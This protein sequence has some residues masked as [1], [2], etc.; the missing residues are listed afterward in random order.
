M[1]RGILEQSEG[2]S[3]G[4][5]EGVAQWWCTVTSLYKNMD[6]IPHSKYMGVRAQIFNLAGVFPLAS[7]GCCCVWCAFRSG[8]LPCRKGGGGYGCHQ[9][10]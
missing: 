7:Y 5:S 10:H 6:S 1:D 8:G 3:E 2:L 4:L 9:A